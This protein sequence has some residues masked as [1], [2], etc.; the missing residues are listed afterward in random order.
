VF[1]GKEEERRG[2]GK[3]RRDE[4]EGWIGKNTRING[5]EC[6]QR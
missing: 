4:E 1:K 5:I 6:F 3:G 2:K